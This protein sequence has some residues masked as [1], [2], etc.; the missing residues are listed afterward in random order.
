MFVTVW[1]G[2]VEIS[3]GKL[4]YANAAHEDPV[5]YNKDTGFLED[6]T[7]H[8]IPIGTMKEYKYLNH[9]VQ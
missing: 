7:K 9:E 1:L 3:T 6:E 8:G 4:T 2:I 5:I